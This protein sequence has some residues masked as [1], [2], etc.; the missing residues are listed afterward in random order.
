MR[1]ATGFVLA[2]LAAL[3]SCAEP[4]APVQPASVE[5]SVSELTLASLTESAPLVAT[6]KSSNGTVLTGVTLQWTSSDDAIATVSASGV[7]TAVGNGTARI[8]VSAGSSISA[9]TTVTVEQVPVSLSFAD[10]AFTITALT[11]TTSIPVSFLD[12]R[13]QVIR[14]IAL[15]WSSSDSLVAAVASTGLVT[16][17]SNGVVT[18]SAT[19]GSLSASGRVRVSQVATAVELSRTGILLESLTDTVRAA[20]I[21]VDR[22]GQPLAGIA[23]LWSTFD[24]AIATVT[25][26][27]L[28]TG[29]GTGTATI[30]ARHDS[31]V[32]DITVVVNQTPASL[33]LSSSALQFESLTDTATIIATVKDARGHLVD[34]AIVQWISSDT[35]RVRVNNAGLTTSI[36]NGA[37]VVTATAGELS[38]PVTV[39]VAQVAASL[40]IERDSLR[41]VAL[42]D[43]VPVSATVRDA[44]GVL[45]PQAVVTWSV[46][47]TG[48]ATVTAEGAIIAVSNGATSASAT[49]GTASD[50]LSVIV[51]QFART[52]ETTTLNA[53]LVNIGDTLI[54]GGTLFDARGTA[55]VGRAP[56]WIVGDTAVVTVS[57]FGVVHA[58]AFG[59]SSVTVMADSALAVAYIRV[60]VPL[61][62]VEGATIY[63]FLETG[64]AP[65]YTYE[66]VTYPGGLIS[67][68]PQGFGAFDLWAD[69]QDDL[70]MPLS[71]A[72]GTGLD[73]RMKPF[74]FRNDAGTFVDATASV[75]APAIASVRRLAEVT[76]PG[77]PF[78]GL[79]GVN[80]DT[81]DGRRADALMMSAGAIPTDVTSRV[82]N[83][84]LAAV[85]GRP[86]ATNS[87][88]M[89]GGDI[90]GD[91]R[92]DFV[93]GDW[94]YQD[95]NTCK[96]Y[97]LVQGTD[98][99]WSVR[100]D[101]TLFRLTYN[102]PMVNPGVGQGSN[103]LI[104]LHL[105]DF[106]GDG[107]G[108]IV[109]GYGHGSTA[110]WIFMNDGAG[111]FSYANAHALP[112]PP[113]GI[114]NSM[115]L[116]TFSPDINGDGALDLVIAWSRYV[117]YYAGTELQI[118]INDGSGN[119]T[120][121]T[122]LRLRNIPGS[123]L[124]AQRLAWTDRFQFIDANG[125]GQLDIVGS[126]MVDNV[127]KVRIWMK[128]GGTY[129]EIVVEVPAG[130]RGIPGGWVRR[131]D[132][133]LTTVAFQTTWVDAEGTASRNWFTQFTLDRVI[134]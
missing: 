41:L 92:T 56:Q 65:S 107:K 84:P 61:Q 116:K 33:E 112:T 4:T 11:D 129:N 42:P 96:P 111:N 64:R 104:D 103:L 95:C 100:Q 81:H 27:G 68:F 17:R 88:S 26:E 76:R 89:A 48:V 38:V 63:E 10:T 46:V 120:D 130:F 28:I 106:N 70:F 87:H 124:P 117:P 86:H 5:L 115:H 122:T 118:L 125:D 105:E 126:Q 77:D 131:P 110:S 30:R 55:I 57:N 6:V 90:N 97:F 62:V 123:E 21:V 2:S 9:S 39:D 34:A 35:S 72:Y 23:A 83:L 58:K 121:E 29:V 1:S 133:R 108:D 52:V 93:V 73:T 80:H 79:F 31:L 44:L 78:R 14:N 8:S 37:A 75:G 16:A 7:V 114:D 94:V 18:V 134:R 113:F 49:S 101:T 43:T 53:T 132:G 47:N 24:S 22:K 15:T 102:H 25:A 85:F 119:F 109:A 3:L 74:F 19:A 127:G 91:G 45:M 66:G 12:A 51:Q 128:A 54:L 32:G 36:A 67:Y 13:Q 20:A 50:S 98:G 99:R 71:K 60:D 40:S 82:D 59:S 69:G